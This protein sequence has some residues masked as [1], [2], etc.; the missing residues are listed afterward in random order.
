MASV[1]TNATFIGKGVRLSVL[2]HMFSSTA[3]LGVEG[4]LCIVY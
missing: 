4:G 1:I 2:R 3:S